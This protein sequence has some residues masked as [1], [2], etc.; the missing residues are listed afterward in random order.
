[1]PNVVFVGRVLPYGCTVTVH[2]TLSITCH[3]PHMDAVYKIQIQNSRIRIPCAVPSY[4][5]EDKNE[6]L[7]MALHL[8][9]SIVDLIAFQ[10]CIFLEVFLDTFVDPDGRSTQIIITNPSLENICSSYDIDSSRFLPFYEM[11]ASKIELWPSINELVSSIANPHHATVNCARAIEGIKY[12]IATPGVSRSKAW[13]QFREA[14]RIGETYLRLI[15]DNSAENRHGKRIAVPP[16]VIS[17][18]KSR[19]WVIMNRYLEYIKR[20][21]QQLPENEFRL[22]I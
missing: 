1:M 14:L 11:I 2:A 18:I 12:L 17:E 9:R 8:A 10:K 7:S 5:I 13:E 19:S 22:L 3:F 4:L 21:E 20:G 15:T 6:L 16:D